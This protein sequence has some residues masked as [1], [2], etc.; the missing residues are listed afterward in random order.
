MAEQ[1]IDG[2]GTG[3]RTK[4]DSTNHLAVRSIT[5]AESLEGAIDGNQY[6]V[7]SGGMALT[8]AT[9]SA[10]LY[11]ENNEEFPLILNRIIF[12]AAVSTG[13]T[14][15][16]CAVSVTV[17]PTGLGSGS[18]NPAVGINSNFGSSNT[19]TLTSSEIGQEA[20][21]VTGGSAGP[22]FFFPDKLT[23]TFPS[24]IVLP[25]GSSIAISVTPPASNSSLVVAASINVHKFIED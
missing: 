12:G 14:T 7:T 8:S 24:E 3:K 10:V 2:T 18:G 1:I 17:N 16:V 25:K 13:G 20:A 6:I 9:A 23:S 11:F 19:L 4:V 15:N 21:T 5:E 22:T